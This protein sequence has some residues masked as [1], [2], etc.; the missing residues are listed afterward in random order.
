[1]LIITHP[2]RVTPA[3]IPPTQENDMSTTNTTVYIHAPD[4]PDADSC[5][6]VLSAEHAECDRCGVE[7]WRG[8]YPE[9]GGIVHAGHEMLCDD[10]DEPE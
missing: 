4:S 7:G 1:M 3:A 6:D 8:D 10:C 2:E 5:G 9:Q